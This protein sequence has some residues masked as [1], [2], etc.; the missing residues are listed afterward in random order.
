[1]QKFG[2]NKRRLAVAIGLVIGAGLAACGGGKDSHDDTP[3]TPP[4]ASVNAW[5][6]ADIIAR[7]AAATTDTARE[8]I[9]NQRAR[10]LLAA[11]TLEQKMQQLTGAMPELVPELP[12]CYGGRHVTGIAALDIPTLRITNGPVGLGQN[13]CV[14][15]SILDEVKA[16][17][18][19]FTAAYTDVS[20]AQATALPSAMGVAASFDPAVATTY[21]DV[22]GTEMSDLALH[23][24]EAPGVNMARIPVLGRNF[25]YFG[26]DPFLTGTM[27]VAET[28]AIQARGAIAMPKHFV[29]NE[30]ETN[31][32]KIQTTIDAQVLRELYLL[33]FEMTV[34]DGKAASIMCAYNYVNGVSSCESK[35]MLT[36]VLRNDWGFT[37]YVQSDFFAMKSTVSTMQAG[38]DHEMPIPQYWS[39]PLLT[40]G[41]A[42]GALNTAQFDKALERRYTMMFKYGVFDRPIKQSPIDFTA[43]GQKAR[44]AGGK[45]AVL[46]QNNGALPIAGSAQKIVLIGKA[47]QVYAQMAVAGG[48]RVGVA[49]AGGSSDVMPHYTVTPLDGLRNTLKALGNTTATVQLILVDDANGS[50]TLD[51]ATISFADARAAAASADAVVVMAGTIAEEG[52]DRLTTAD[53]STLSSN[54]VPIA[55]GASAA[56]GM[57]LDWY[58]AGSL[59]TPATPNGSAAMVR[60][61]QTVAMIQAILAAN[62]TTAKSMAQKTALVLKDNAGVAMDPTLLGAA[63]PSILEVWFPGQED[64][65]IVADL[66]FGVTNPSGKLPVTFPVRGMGFLDNVSDDQYPGR[67]A[68]DGVTQTVEYTEKL[69]MGYRWY[70]GNVSG[71]CAVVNGSNPCVAFPFGHGL[72]YTSFNVSSPAVAASG[73]RYTVTATVTNTGTRAGAEVVQVYLSLPAGA[74]SVGAPQPPKRLVGFQKVQLGAGESRPVTITID[75]AASHHPLSVWSKT[76]NQWITPAGNYTVLLGRSSA[77]RDLVQA[78]TFSR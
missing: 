13:D 7:Q 54:V 47:S 42:S 71:Q 20:S 49:I 78:G 63:G 64:G 37:G 27:A 41:L 60:N 25:E 61:S 10:L 65:N 1:M 67:V 53:G 4:A 6:R 44:E 51:G 9:A 31:R 36:G 3:S 28:K 22:I 73:T 76:Y 62:S 74:S 26:E 14:S 23:V 72:S 55:P 75:P 12:E 24:F 5:M 34:K 19:S 57:S 46:L 21:G 66:L 48:A 8:S 11:M 43:N 45:M 16:G 56:D 69:H 33:P 30:Q 38:M 40:A 32:Q 59:T 15:A 58:V 2:T 29:G 50:A 77:P 70:D 18:K 68:P 52:A 39:A 17:K 35:D